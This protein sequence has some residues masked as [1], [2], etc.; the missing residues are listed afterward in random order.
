MFTKDDLKQL[1]S[2]GSD[3]KVVEYQID[4]FRRGFPFINLDRPAIVGDGIKAFNQRDAKKLSYYY[5]SN[6]KRY[7]LLKF[8]PASG[9]S[10]LCFLFF[11]AFEISLLG[12]SRSPKYIHFVGQTATQAGFSPLVMRW[13]QKVHLST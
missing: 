3:Q 1:H 9:A 2:R 11:K 12:S 7:E 5:D 4:N 10:T 6:S 8:V 13:L